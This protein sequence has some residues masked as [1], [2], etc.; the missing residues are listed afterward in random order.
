MFLLYPENCLHSEN[1]LLKASKNGIAFA[2]FHKRAMQQLQ[3]VIPPLPKEVL[4]ET[5]NISLSEN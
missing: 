1:G 2:A 4:K 5:Q 3:T